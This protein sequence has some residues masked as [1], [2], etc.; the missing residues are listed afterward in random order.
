MLKKDNDQK[1][2]IDAVTFCM[3]FYIFFLISQVSDYPT[4]QDYF[5][6]CISE[7]NASRGNMYLICQVFFFFFVCF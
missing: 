1:K 7:V 2:F 3:Q 6:E 4:I 5:G